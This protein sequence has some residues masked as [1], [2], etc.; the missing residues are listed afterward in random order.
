MEMFFSLKKRTPV[1]RDQI[2]INKLLKTKESAFLKAS[3]FNYQ[4]DQHTNTHDYPPPHYP[5]ARF[6]QK[7]VRKSDAHPY[8]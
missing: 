5:F 1:E 8:F 2:I 4:R 3:T 7:S 6:P